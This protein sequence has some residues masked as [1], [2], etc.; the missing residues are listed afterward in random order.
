LQNLCN[1]CIPLLTLI[2]FTYPIIQSL[3]MRGNN[4]WICTASGRRLENRKFKPC[5]FLLMF[6]PAWFPSS[7]DKKW[8]FH[9]L[10]CKTRWTVTKCFVISWNSIILIFFPIADVCFLLQIL[11]SGCDICKDKTSDCCCLLKSRL[12]SWDGVKFSGLLRL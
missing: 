1:L 9:D 2:S 11:V 10:Y 3:K 12:E 5:H 6:D 4:I 7:Q 8:V